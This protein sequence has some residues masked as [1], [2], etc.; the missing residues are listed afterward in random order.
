[1]GEILRSSD[2]VGLFGICPGLMEEDRGGIPGLDG[3]FLAHLVLCKSKRTIIIYFLNFNY[4]IYLRKLSTFARFVCK[5]QWQ[6]IIDQN[7][8]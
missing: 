2:K 5:R 6:R 7:G 1:M 8:E 3:P 4:R